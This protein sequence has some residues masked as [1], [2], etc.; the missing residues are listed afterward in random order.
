M[1]VR[2]AP[3][4]PSRPQVQRKTW[5]TEYRCKVCAGKLKGEKNGVCKYCR[6][7]RMLEEA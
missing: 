1:R 6:L 7:V 5:G 4:R 2:T 3:K